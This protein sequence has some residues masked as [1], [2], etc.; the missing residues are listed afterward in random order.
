MSNAARA[1]ITPEIGE[2]KNIMQD[3]V[4]VDL[5]QPTTYT[6]TAEGQDGQRVTQTTG[7]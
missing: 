7:S 4:D 5:Q 2:L 1:T 3:C 6:L